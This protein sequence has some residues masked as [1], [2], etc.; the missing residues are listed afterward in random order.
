MAQCSITR[1]LKPFV[2][3]LVLVG[4]PYPPPDDG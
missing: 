4:M 1:E 3:P 2:I